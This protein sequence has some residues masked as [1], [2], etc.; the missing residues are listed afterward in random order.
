MRHQWG[1]RSGKEQQ[2]F[3]HSLVDPLLNAGFTVLGYYLNAK[4]EALLVKHLL[5]LRVKFTQWKRRH[6]WFRR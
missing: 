5:P 2:V 4:V 6:P 3:P 1:R